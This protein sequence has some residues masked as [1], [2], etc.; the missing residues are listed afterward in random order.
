LSTLCAHTPTLE[1]DVPF[2]WTIVRGR[3]CLFL[4]FF[5]RNDNTTDWIRPT[6]WIRLQ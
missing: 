4:L 2:V 1:N 3:D 5:S 6:V